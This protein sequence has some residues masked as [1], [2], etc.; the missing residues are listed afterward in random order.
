MTKF[1]VLHLIALLLLSLGIKAES[2]NILIYMAADSNLASAAVQ[3]FN[4]MESVNLPDGTKVWLQTDLPPEH[5]LGGTRRWE[6][7]HDSSEQITSRQIS[8]L[9]N[10]SSGSVQTLRE[11][12]S[13]GCDRYSADRTMLVIWSHGSGWS[14]ADESKW[15]CPDYTSEEALSVADGDLKAAL[16]GHPRFDIL[17]FDACSMQ[18]IEVADEVKGFADY[19]IGSEELVP[20][21]GF[22]YPEILPLFG[23]NLNTILQQ[24]PLLYSQSYAV[25]GSQ[26]P[27]SADLVSTCSVLSSSALSSFVD[28][29]GEFCREYRRRI[30]DLAVWREECYSLGN[31]SDID[32]GQFLSIAEAHTEDPELKSRMQ[33]LQQIWESV[34]V[35]QATSGITEPVGS[36]S[37][38]FPLYY[39]VYGQNLPHY[40]KLD[41]SRTRWQSLLNN[42]WE[43]PVFIPINVNELKVE[44]FPGHLLLSFTP[45]VH[46]DSVYYV[47][48]HSDASFMEIAY[49]TMQTTGTISIPLQAPSSGTFYVRTVY[50]E[51]EI[52]EAVLNYT[53]AETGSELLVYP[54][55]G[56][57]LLQASWNLA[58][59]P[60][61]SVTMELFNTRGQVVWETELPAEQQG[62]RFLGTEQAIRCLPAG[63]Y[64]LKVKTRGES[65]VS[66]LIIL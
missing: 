28:H 39:Y 60:E 46:P 48:D 54:N 32:L 49:Y 58:R 33:Y 12:I 11:F 63:I 45:A 34:V 2:W 22:P 24:I 14:K 50:P 56:R 1:K 35:S 43:L 37:I 62:Y 15:I 8:H 6:L 3:D 66:R 52:R 16:S 47:I 21:T 65:L 9:G 55:P 13:W 23:Q 36:A 57:E 61:G 51:G 25:G 20:V 38:W 42:A 5:S 40:L 26:N 17:L 29:W 7:G 4:S 18:A 64:F 10:L 59:Q 41:F 53:F 19:V 30:P 27:H 44:K 31:L